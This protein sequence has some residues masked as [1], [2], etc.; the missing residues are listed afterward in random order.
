VGALAALLLHTVNKVAMKDL[1]KHLFSAKAIHQNILNS[2]EKSKNIGSLNVLVSSG[3]CKMTTAEN[4]AG[5]GL[6]LVHLK[7]IHSRDG[8]DGLMNTFTMKNCEVL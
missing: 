4:I 3:V 6:K 7:K 2:R 1:C 5:S 8:E